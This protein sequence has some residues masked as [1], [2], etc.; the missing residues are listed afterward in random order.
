MHDDCLLID[1]ALRGHSASFGQLVR[2]YQ[3]RL[4]NAMVYVVGSREDAHDVVQDAFFKAFVTL[5]QLKRAGA[6]YAWL[7]RI[8]F[9]VAVRRRQKE[10]RSESIDQARETNGR[11][12][13]APEAG[14]AEWLEQRERYQQV[15]EAIGNLSEEHRIVVVLRGIDGCRYQAIAEMLDLPI[16][17]VRSRLHRARL[18]ILK[19]LQGALAADD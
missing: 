15:H 4:Y 8:A 19:Q 18:Q 9:N 7:Y 3:D 10:L 16:G 5:D 11:E 2:K 12:P 14:P 6:F 1:A 13:I 17:T